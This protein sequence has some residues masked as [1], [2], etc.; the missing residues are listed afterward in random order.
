MSAV[1]LTTGSIVDDVHRS[2]GLSGRWVHSHEEDEQGRTVFRSGGF[3]FP[4]SRG[5]LAFTLQPDGTAG[6]DA[7]GPT[8]RPV[9]HEGSWHIDGDLLVI[10][11]PHWS[12]EFSV[13]SLDDDRLVLRT[14]RKES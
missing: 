12:G 10:T 3:E 9:S 14:L 11:S 5:R 8:D 13:E 2:E 1:S 4:P 7:P 6:V